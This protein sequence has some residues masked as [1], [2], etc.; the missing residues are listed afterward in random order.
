MKTESIIQLAVMSHGKSG[1]G[2]KS[3]F[4]VEYLCCMNEKERTKGIFSIIPFH[5]IEGKIRGIVR[6][7]KK[8]KRVGQHFV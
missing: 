1:G 6:G 7:K 3:A 4:S 8:K 5:Q 2:E